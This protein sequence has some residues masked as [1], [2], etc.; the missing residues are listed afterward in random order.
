M[1]RSTSPCTPYSLEPQTGSSGCCQYCHRPSVDALVSGWQSSNGLMTTINH[2]YIA[3]CSAAKLSHKVELMIAWAATFC[4]QARRFES[5]SLT[6][7]WQCYVELPSAAVERR[8]PLRSEAQSSTV[9]L[10]VEFLPFDE[11]SC[12]SL[13]DKGLN[14]TGSR[15]PRM[16]QQAGI[17]SDPRGLPDFWR[18][19]PY[20]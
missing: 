20:Q 17:A 10:R 18:E 19:A 16:S 12:S 8:Q 5:P 15:Q 11:P 9:L 2:L 4:N 1:T 14:A 3:T 13:P 7:N 6:G